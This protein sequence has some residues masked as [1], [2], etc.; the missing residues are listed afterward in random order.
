MITELD[1]KKVLTPEDEVQIYWEEEFKEGGPYAF[2]VTA[3]TRYWMQE[4]PFKIEGQKPKK[5]DLDPGSISG[6]STMHWS[7][8]SK[9]LATKNE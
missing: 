4:L 2:D 6:I 1:H 9:F 3:T 5:S 8:D 7:H